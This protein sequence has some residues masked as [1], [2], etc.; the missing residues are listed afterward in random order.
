MSKN[1]VEL[2]AATNPGDAERWRAMVFDSP[3]PD[4]YYLPAY[5]WASSKI[6][7]SEPVAFVGGSDSGR[8]LAPLLIRRLSALVNGS[9]VGWTD[10]CSPYGYG[11]L[12]R[13]SGDQTTD[14]RDLRCFFDDLY[15]WCS[16]RDVVC[17]VLRLHPLMKQEEWFLPTEEWPNLHS[18]PLRGATTAIDVENWDDTHDRPFSLRKDRRSDLNAARRGSRVTW[19][20][21]EDPDVQLTLDRFHA[22]YERAMESHHADNFYR[23]PVSYFSRLASLGSDLGIALAWMGDQL[24]GAS[25]FLAGRDYAH[26]HLAAA[27]EIGR[28]CKASTLLVIEGAKWARERGCKLLH[29]GGGLRPG[30]S[31]EDFKRSFGGQSYRYGYLT[32]IADAERYGQL[33][34]LPNPPWPYRASVKTPADGH[35]T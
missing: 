9:R 19:A 2:L 4:V 29:L 34:S 14:A 22:L 11:G 33:C 16:M 20:S 21:G 31:L 10:A 3:T 26:Y 15:E 6:E 24:A 8:F 23:F 13:L 12:L 1:A 32:Y 17:C 35:N 28:K 18:I 7:Q 25:I 5:A 27:N 30:D